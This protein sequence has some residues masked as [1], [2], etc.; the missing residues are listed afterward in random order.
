MHF[1][2]DAD[3]DND[4]VD[5]CD[6]ADLFEEWYADVSKGGRFY[7]REKACAVI[8]GVFKR[9]DEEKRA[10]R[11]KPSTTVVEN[12][13]K[14]FAE[15]KKLRVPDLRDLLKR[16]QLNTEG[17]KTELLSRLAKHFDFEEQITVGK[18]KAVCKAKKIKMTPTPF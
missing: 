13:P 2:D 8:R 12:L 7:G 9:R 4:G 15:L 16:E 18:H 10:Q 5:I 11:G 17:L 14:T 1:N 6:M 3:L